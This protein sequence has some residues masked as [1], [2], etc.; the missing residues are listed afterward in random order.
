M[1]NQSKYIV[2]YISDV[3]LITMKYYINTD[4]AEKM[5][6]PPLHNPSPIFQCIAKVTS[7][8]KIEK[9]GD[10]FSDLYVADL[11]VYQGEDVVE[12]EEGN[13][14]V[15]KFDESKIS[16]IVNKVALKQFF[17][18]NMIGKDI[19]IVGLGKKGA[20]HRYYTA[21]LDEAINQGV[22]TPV[23]DEPKQVTHTPETTPKSPTQTTQTTF[24]P[25]SISEDLLR[26][27]EEIKKKLR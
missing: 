20:Y 19:V 14:E 18:D 1:K 4:K 11:D 24:T 21:T 7:I 23:E 12:D 2:I 13:R 25:S 8:R 3:N 9:K 15:V 27:V 26:K 5:I 22:V 16:L 17:S 10:M 6:A